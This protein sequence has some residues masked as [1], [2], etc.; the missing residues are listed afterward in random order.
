MILDIFFVFKSHFNTVFEM[1]FIS[2]VNKLD[3]FIMRVETNFTGSPISKA[4]TCMKIY[5]Y[6][7][8]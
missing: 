2:S 8:K 4:L 3:M 1:H 6:K 5:M 7:Q